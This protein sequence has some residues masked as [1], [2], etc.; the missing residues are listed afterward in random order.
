MFS[1]IGSISCRMY[2]NRTE[3][4][5]GFRKNFL[6]GF[7]N[8]IVAFIAAAILHLIVFV[9]PFFTFILSFMLFDPVIFFLSVASVSIILIERLILAI[10]YKI[11]PFYAFTHPL[12]VLWFQMLAIV[13]IR[14]YYSG[15]MS[16][17]KGRNV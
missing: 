11:N 1:G 10:W 2:S 15:R 16:V 17:W 12:A 3:I 4:L 8:N 6:L 13:K 5:E 7:N 9:L 14:D